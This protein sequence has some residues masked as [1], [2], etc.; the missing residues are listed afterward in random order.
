[1]HTTTCCM[2]HPNGLCLSI[3]SSLTPEQHHGRSRSPILKYKCIC[4][5]VINLFWYSLI[6]L[7]ITLRPVLIMR[8]FV[9][10]HSTSQV[11]GE[12]DL[13]YSSLWD[14]GIRIQQLSLEHQPEKSLARSET[15]GRRDVSKCCRR[16]LLSSEI[17]LT[18]R[19]AGRLSV[20]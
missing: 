18:R 3:G 4:S 8:G 13:D 20:R 6:C 10:G 19:D 16:K 1:M 12:L 5:Q 15:E 2:S 7:V 11:A 9:Q 14:D 17:K